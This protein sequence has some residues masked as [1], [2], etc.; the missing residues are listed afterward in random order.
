MLQKIIQ[1]IMQLW[2]ERRIQ[3]DIEFHPHEENE[4]CG[5][6]DLSGYFGRRNFNENF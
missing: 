5:C 4:Q 1:G 6:N 3:T 2:G